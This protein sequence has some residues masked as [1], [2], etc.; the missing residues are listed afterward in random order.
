MDA[1]LLILLENST[2][3]L[4]FLVDHMREFQVHEIY[5]DREVFGE[6]HHL[7]P[8]LRKYEDKFREYLRMSIS[9]FDYILSAIDPFLTKNWC[10][11]HK[12]PIK[13]AEQLVVTLR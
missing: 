11:L 7:Y 4:D 10:H 3:K 12:Q 13:G 5:K 6:Y 9:T 8:L 2:I 1:E